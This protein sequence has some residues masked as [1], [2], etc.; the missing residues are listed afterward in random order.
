MA[1]RVAVETGRRVPGWVEV[2]EGLAA[3]DV[4]VTDG[5][6]SLRDGA[7]VEVA[8]RYEGAVDAFDP[9]SGQSS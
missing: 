6:L 7:V 5:V 9:K 1:R 3:G 2:R 4:V 8:G